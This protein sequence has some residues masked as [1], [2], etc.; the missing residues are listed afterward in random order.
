MSSKKS[1]KTAAGSTGGST[2]S[3]DQVS[4]PTYGISKEFAADNPTRLPSPSDASLLAAARIRRELAARSGRQ[5][6]SLVGT[7]VYSNSFLGS[8]G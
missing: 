2:P 5:S 6:T 3:L 8:V 1:T 4:A 7:S